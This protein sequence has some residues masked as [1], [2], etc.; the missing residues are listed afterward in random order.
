MKLVFGI[1]II[2]GLLYLS[3]LNWRLSVKAA[4]VLVVIEG[5]LRKWVLPQASDVVYFLKDFVLLGAYLRYYVFPSSEQKLTIKN[6]LLSTFVF[7]ASGWCLFQAF[8][9]SLGSPLV[10]IFGLK[11]YLFYI[12]LMW[13]L[14]NLFQ[15]E[16]ELYQ[17]LRNYMVLAI[18]VGILGIFQFLSP[19]DS[20]I[21]VY[22]PGDV[23]NVATFGVNTLVRITGTFSYIGSYGVYLIVCFGLLIP[24]IAAKQS[25]WWKCIN[26][27]SLL[28]VVINSLMNGSRSVVFA[29]GLFLLGYFGIKVITLS[30]SS[31]RFIQQFLLPTIVIAMAASIWFQ[32]ALETF[33][34]RT[35]INK[36]VG[37]RIAAT[38]Q[39]PMWFL[40]Y[41][42]LD[43]YGTGATHQATQS[44]RRV[45]NL[46]PGE[47]VPL[48][49]EPEPGRI[50]LELGPI[51]FF[52]WYLLRLSIVIYLWLVFWKLKRP[53]LKEL[54]LAI[55]LIQAIQLYS[56]LVFNHAFSV[57]YWF[58]SGFIFL[59]PR[60]EQIENSLIEQQL[61]QDVL[62]LYLPDSP[63]R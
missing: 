41:K 38:F 27:L 16:L 45:L 20:P 23:K 5:A 28:L 3:C 6:N 7:L 42:E 53:R 9:P 63:Y 62:S 46:P 17:F 24:L 19:A 15:S 43:G 60:L 44:L 52:F 4:L 13:M 11:V 26:I 12:P 30:S 1:P 48:V 18:P 14:P 35:T 29:L 47:S 39:E 59:L 55:F 54:A 2:V 61:Q 37:G 10:G 56:L 58:L 25:Y 32:P 57:Y 50:M 33:M 51:G 21:N 31:L 36:D 40:Q 49:Y 22:A 8:N 34:L